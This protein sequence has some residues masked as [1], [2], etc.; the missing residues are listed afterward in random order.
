MTPLRI[1]KVVL[2]FDPAGE[3]RPALELAVRLA[4]HWHARL[5]GIFIEDI[6]LLDA[7]ALPVS[8][9][10]LSPTGISTPFDAGQVNVQIEALAARTR[11]WLAAES[12]SLGLE[13]SFEVVRGR[14]SPDIF[15]SAELDFLILE[16]TSRPFAGRVHVRSRW[17][18]PLRSI[19]R[20][21]MLFRAAPPS[22]RSVAA[23]VGPEPEGSSRLLDVAGQL[24][25]QRG[26]ALVALARDPAQFNSGT[27]GVESGGPGTGAAS[28]SIELAPQDP[29]ELYR[30]AGELGCGMIVVGSTAPCLGVLLDTVADNDCSL[31][32]L[33]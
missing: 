28:P 10:V 31:M 29:T 23:I 33:P 14:L 20:P 30:R 22:A 32:I 17:S 2:G 12:G 18:G 13:W 1:D 26:G 9:E 6:G 11:D 27:R 19:S 25:R 16:G 21:V 4:A 24:A 15:A 3:N 5:H 8:K 7:A